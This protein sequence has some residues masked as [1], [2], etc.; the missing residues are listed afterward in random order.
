MICLRFVKDEFGRNREPNL[1]LWS[2]RWEMTV[3]HTVAVSSGCG[4]KH[5]V[6]TLFEG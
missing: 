3:A 5:A 1:Q 4:G 2:F 6:H